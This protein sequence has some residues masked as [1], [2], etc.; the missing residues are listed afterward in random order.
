MVYGV[1]E[2][3][4]CG[5]RLHIIDRDAME[6]YVKAQREPPTMP[7]R[8]WRRLGLLAMPTRKQIKKP[9]LGCCPECGFILIQQ[10]KRYHL[11]VV[12]VIVSVVSLITL[13]L[14]YYTLFKTGI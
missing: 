3:R 13:I 6:Q 9:E 2:C 8:Q 4:R 14:G 1:D 12:I 5:T 7:E 11:R 10:N